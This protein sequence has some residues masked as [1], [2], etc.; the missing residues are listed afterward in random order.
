[1]DLGL[2]G[3][4]VIVTGAGSNIGR[5]TALAFAHEGARLTV[6]DIDEAQ[7]RRVVALAESVGSADPRYFNADVTAMA[8]VEVLFGA[9][10]QQRGSIDVLVNCV[11]LSVPAPFADTGPDLWAR[12]IA[13]NYVSVLNC[14]HVALRHMV[15]QSRGAIVSISSD[16]ARVGE[17]RDAVYSGTKAA[18][19]TFMKTIAKEH[20][21]HGIRCNTVS[22]GATI[23]EDSDEIGAGSMWSS[24]D[25]EVSGERLDKIARLLPLR[26]LGR[27]RDIANA[28]VFL[29]SDVAAGHITGQV[30]SVSG[31]YTMT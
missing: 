19:N 7:T 27:P 12:L 11:G 10:Q 18:V 6:V 31:G 13:L 17:A 24:P 2:E 15:P 21:R 23:P 20:G 9:V 14:T 5:A 1:M 25:F 4:S 8:D 29:A 22:P 28:I 30:L 26:K 16:A 3:R